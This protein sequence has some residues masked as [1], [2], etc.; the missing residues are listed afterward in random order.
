MRSWTTAVTLSLA[1]L[2]SGCGEDGGTAQEPGQGTPQDTSESGGDASTGEPDALPTGDTTPEPDGVNTPEPDALPEAPNALVPELGTTQTPAGVKVEQLAGK[3]WLNKPTDLAFDP[4]QPDVLWIA[5]RGDDSFVIFEDPGSDDPVVHKF[6]D[7]NHHFAEEVS[8]IAFSDIGTF[9]TAQESNNTY[10]GLAQADNFMGPT[11][12]SSDLDLF[13]E[14]NETNP[15]GPHLDMLHGSTFLVGI[16]AAGQNTFYVFNG[17][18]GGVD[19]YDFKEP[20]VPGG[21]DHSDGI[22][23]RLFEGVLARVPGAPGHME[24]D[25]ATGILYVADTGNGRIVRVYTDTGEQGG[26]IFPNFDPGT[27]FHAW[28]GTQ[29]DVLPLSSD[30]I[31]EQPGGLALHRGLLWVADFA[32]GIIHAFTLSGTHLGQ[33]DTGRGEASVA[34]LTFDDQGR[35]LFVDTLRHNLVRISPL[36]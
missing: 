36:D 33:L 32:T 26:N 28:E 4:E 20:H 16:A 31:L 14:H 19:F 27:T 5:N 10:N 18:D 21:D 8:A 6:V 9:G 1:L 34:G 7:Y 13:Y 23:R 15:G 25:P 29:W 2:A 12:W 35:L 30:G 11:L 22:K 3:S 24:L 17:G